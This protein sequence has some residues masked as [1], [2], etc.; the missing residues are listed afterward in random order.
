M[1]AEA[2]H[3]LGVKLIPLDPE[4]KASPAGQVAELAVEGSFRDPEKINE[5]ASLCDILT[6]E[7][8]HVNCEIL[9]E[10]EGRGVRVEPS[11]RTVRTIQDKYLQKQ[12]MVESGIAVGDFMDTPTEQDVAKAGERWGYPLMLKAKKL[13][14][15]GRGNAVV[16]D[17][18]GVSEA[19]AKLG[20]KDLY[21]EKWVPFTKEVA[22]MVVRSDGGE[23]AAYP[24]V[25]AVQLDSICHTTLAPAD[26]GAALAEQASA[27][28][29]KA[30]ASLWGA[31]IFGVEMFL[32]PEGDVLLNEVAPR[33]HN[34]GHYTYEAC[35]CDQFENHLRAILGLPLGGTRLRV[36]ASMMLNVL[37]NGDMAETKALMSKALAIPGAALHW[38]GKA[39]ARKGRKMAHITFCADTMEELRAR[40]APYGL[41]QDGAPQQHSTAL[42][43]I[44]MGSDSDLPTMKAAADALERFGVPYELTIVSAHRTPARLVTYSQTAAARGLRVIIAG[45]GGAAHLP[46]MCAAMTP[47]PVIGVPVKTSTLSGVDSLHSIVQMPRGVP[48]ATVAIGNAMNAGLLAVRMLG[49]ADAKLLSQ[50]ADFMGEQEQEVLAKA[51]AMEASGWKAYL[52]A[53]SNQSTTVGI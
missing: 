4:G 31:G 11:S 29:S 43:G 26:V 34:T 15:D 12:H 21:A 16:K 19:F 48:V 38:Y 33:P 25:D 47:L 46:G 17:A 51:E 23:T 36:G 40:V 8:E 37:G 50:M 9:E 39:E 35:E 53:K 1:M 14:Y 5:L 24:L 18:A 27:L 13:A 32:T 2:A 20:G 49:M 28:A 45:A 30:V 41:L 3:R 44:I 6:M 7:I 52:A 10:L 22:I 42:V